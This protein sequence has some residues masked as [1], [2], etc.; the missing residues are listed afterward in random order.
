MRTGENGR[1]AVFWGQT[2]INGLEAAPLSELVVGAAWSWRGSILGTAGVP[3]SDDES[4]HYA[5]V[6]LVNGA[7]RFG[8]DLMFVAGQIAPILVFENEYPER[9]E[10][11]WVSAVV[12]VSR[13]ADQ[14]DA[15]E[16]V[17]LFPSQPAASQN[18]TV[19]AVPTLGAA[20]E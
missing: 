4:R 8:A 5:R 2:E 9:E 19:T 7:R 6:E 20:A 15:E 1:I 16:T 13:M 17:V 10:E 18:R 3:I 11:F 14:T 12:R